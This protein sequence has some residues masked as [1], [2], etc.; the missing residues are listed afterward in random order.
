MLSLQQ[1]KARI[2]VTLRKW[3]LTG[4]CIGKNKKYLSLRAL[5]FGAERN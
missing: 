5:A 4:G 1:D 3:I 2:P